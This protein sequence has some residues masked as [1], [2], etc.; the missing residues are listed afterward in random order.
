MCACVLVCVPQTAPTRPIQQP[1]LSTKEEASS[2]ESVE[3]T[4][5]SSLGSSDF[6]SSIL[7]TE[8]VFVTASEL[9]RSPLTPSSGHR[10]EVQVRRARVP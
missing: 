8:L 3:S 4:T 6:Y 5:D 2:G 7:R 1:P 9:K 10:G